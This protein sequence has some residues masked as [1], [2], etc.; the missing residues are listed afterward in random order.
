[1]ARNIIAVAE[2]RVKDV[3]AIPVSS[4]AMR[5]ISNFDAPIRGMN[6]TVTIGHRYA[7]LFHICHFQS[8]E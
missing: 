8:V 5:R 4:V 2:R 1:V 7:I 3:A 6:P